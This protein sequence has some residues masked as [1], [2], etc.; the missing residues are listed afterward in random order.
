MNISSGYDANTCFIAGSW[1]KIPWSMLLSSTSTLTLAPKRHVLHH[2]TV[3]LLKVMHVYYILCKQDS[4][5][6]SINCF[7]AASRLFRVFP[8]LDLAFKLLRSFK[9][10][11]Y[12][13]LC[14][15]LSWR[16]F[17]LHLPIA[18]WP[19]VL[20][21]LTFFLC[22]GSCMNSSCNGEGNLTEPGTH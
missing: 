1:K 13:L 5:C 4:P 16:S 14:A 10:M 12:P 3:P 8:A 17:L 11:T 15:S 18:L 2:N 7:T 21:Q 19:L 6:L 9:R 22:W 20:L